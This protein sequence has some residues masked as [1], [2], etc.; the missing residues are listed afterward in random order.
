MSSKNRQDFNTHL[1][2]YLKSKGYRGVLYSPQRY[3]EY[4]LRMLD[5]RDVVQQD[6]R[7]VDDPAVRR[8][9]TG[10]EDRFNSNLEKIYSEMTSLYEQLPKVKYG[11][12]EHTNLMKKYSDLGAKADILIETKKVLPKP[13]KVASVN[14]WKTRSD[15]EA[16]PYQESGHTPY[17][18][19]AIYSDIDMS[20]L[21]LDSD[22]VRRALAE[23][24]KS[25]VLSQQAATLKA[26]QGLGRI[27]KSRIAKK[28][29]DVPKFLEASP[30]E[31]PEADTLI[32]QLNKILPPL[33]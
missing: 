1:T 6:I 10:P 16:N 28:H 7:S 9:Y 27:G 29:Q 33:E 26:K 32:D 22:E 11:G 4:E 15:Y 21:R 30:E 2:D 13:K 20:K 24:V 8:L 31:L 23:E 12:V 19:G 17:A 5:A 25:G 14:E 3:N 18:L